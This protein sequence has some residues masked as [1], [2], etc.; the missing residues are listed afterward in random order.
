MEIPLI[1]FPRHFGFTR[2]P[3]TLDSNYSGRNTAFWPGSGRSSLLFPH[4]ASIDNPLSGEIPSIERTILNRLRNMRRFDSILSFQIGDRP[5]HLQDPVVSPGRKTQFVHGQLDQVLAFFVQGAVY[6][7]L[8]R[9]E[10][11]IAIDSVSLV[12]LELNL[13]CLADRFADRGRI[14]TWVIGGQLSVRNGRDL[15]MNVNPVQER[16]RDPGPVSLDLQ[17]RAEACTAGIR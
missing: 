4:F 17:R 1:G 9:P 6:L 15:D 11:G 7:D 2:F 5:R 3:L 8:P 13:A 10:L 14:F 16:T 12:A